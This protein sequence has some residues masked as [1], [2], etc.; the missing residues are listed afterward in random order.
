[1][2]RTR[3]IE[4]LATDGVLKVRLMW[5][6]VGRDIYWGHLIKGHNI[7]FAYHEN[8]EY[9]LKTADA[10]TEEVRYRTQWPPL[11][12]FEGMAAI[13]GFALDKQL[14]GLPWIPYRNER[15]DYMVWIDTRSIR[16]RVLR[17]TILAV[18][19]GRGDLISSLVQSSPTCPIYVYGSTKPWI[20]VQV[21]RDPT[22]YT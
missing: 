7:H 12:L 13:A 5:I 6:Q 3:R 15:I 9:H 18:E 21:G 8:G 22:E 10:G 14:D 17:T 19:P 11:S 16:D 1:M 20:A 2:T 4:I